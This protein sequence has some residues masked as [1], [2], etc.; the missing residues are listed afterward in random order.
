MQRKNNNVTLQG[1]YQNKVM[2]AQ[3][4]DGPQKYQLS[5]SPSPSSPSLPFLTL[6]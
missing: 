5:S 4:I 3:E 6:S 2:D 1:S